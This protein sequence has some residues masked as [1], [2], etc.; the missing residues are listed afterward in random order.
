MRAHEIL[1][2]DRETFERLVDERTAELV[3]IHHELDKARHLSDIGML[4]STV[5]HELRN[6]LGV[7]KT[8]V[9]NINR[10]KQGGALD[11]HLA[12]IDKKIDESNQI[13]TNLL[14]YARIKQPVYEAVRIRDLLRESVESAKARNEGRHVAFRDECG[15]VESVVATLDPFQ[16]M[17]VMS[18]II[19]NAVQAIPAEG[20]G[21]VALSARAVDGMLRILVSDTGAGIDPDILPHVFEPFFTSKSKGT[22]LGLSLCKELVSLHNG[23]INIESEPG[24]GTTVTVVLPLSPGIRPVTA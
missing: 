3:E 8:A 14:M 6:P 22:G 23:S 2:R 18:N 21:T 24:K 12:T 11:K 10:K 1:R 4:A 15:P 7:I 9:Y 13:I 5:A 17:E 19:A 20:G 16:I